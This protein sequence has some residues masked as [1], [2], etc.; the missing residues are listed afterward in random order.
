VKTA[1]ILV[2]PQLRAT[3]PIGAGG[4]Q[5]RALL[6]VEFEVAGGQGRR[7]IGT[8]MAD[9][10]QRLAQGYAVV[11]ADR[12]GVLGPVTAGI[13]G[14]A[15]QARPEAGA[16][17][18]GP[19]HDAEVG[20]VDGPLGPGAQQG[21]GHAQ[22]RR[23]AERPVEAPG[24]RL[25]VEVGP[26]HHQGGAG[27]AGKGEQPELVA[28]RIRAKRASEVAQLLREQIAGPPVGR[29]AAEPVH[30]AARRGAAGRK[31]VEQVV[32]ARIRP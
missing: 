13:G 26:K 7:R 16:L 29:A 2:A 30:P 23:D 14:A 3:S 31:P 9:V 27:S 24:L 1:S 6:D 20:L 25:A 17:L 11:V 12:Q 21:G 15:E 10:C 28:D 22:R 18:V 19:V 32:Q 4:L 8:A 5:H